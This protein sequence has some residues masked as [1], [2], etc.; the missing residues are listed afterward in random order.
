MTLYIQTVPT[1]GMRR[2][3]NSQSSLAQQL[4]AAVEIHN[5]LGCWESEAHCSKQ[6]PAEGT[7]DQRHPDDL[8]GAMMIQHG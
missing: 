4:R 7:R 1:T 8:I 6:V 5:T 3:T 2:F